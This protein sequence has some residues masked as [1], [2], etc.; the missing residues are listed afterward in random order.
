MMAMMTCDVND[1]GGRAGEGGNV[2]GGGG[3]H[4]DG[5][6]CVTMMV[7]GDLFFL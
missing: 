3:D 6:Y 5:G 2:G 4:T 7:Y 1:D